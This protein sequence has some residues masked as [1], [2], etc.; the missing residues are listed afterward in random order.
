MAVNSPPEAEYNSSL[1]PSVLEGPTQESKKLGIAISVI[2]E[3][4]PIS[5]ANGYVEILRINGQRG[6]IAEKDLKP[7]TYPIF[8]NIPGSCTITMS[9]RGQI[10]YEG[11]S[12][13]P[14]KQ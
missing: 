2:Y 1:F 11:R 5:K 14:A 10:V 9:E 13:G 7:F 8:S 4:V 3:K 12:I 6:W